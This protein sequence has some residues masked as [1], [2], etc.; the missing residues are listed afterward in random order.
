MP[1]EYNGDV[2]LNVVGVDLM[3]REYIEAGVVGA[4]QE[5]TPAGVMSEMKRKYN[6]KYNIFQ[7]YYIILYIFITL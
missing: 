2:Y 7:S 3:L 1:R 5:N 4:T 6:K